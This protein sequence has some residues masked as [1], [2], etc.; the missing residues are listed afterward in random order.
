MAPYFDV[1]MVGPLLDFLLEVELY[2]AK[3]IT[4]EKIKLI[5]K[6]NLVDLVEGEYARFPNDQTFQEEYQKLV[7]VL[8]ERRDQLF[9]EIDNEPEDVK[10]VSAFFLNTVLIEELKKSSNF[11][12]ESLSSSHKI[13]VEALENY[14]KYSKF[15]YYK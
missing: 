9:L 5:L 1:H 14:Y 11:S 12:V 7:P 3:L 13:T 2:D 6:T 4:Q 15:K 10:I 8:K